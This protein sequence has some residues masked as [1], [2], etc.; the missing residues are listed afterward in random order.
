MTPIRKILLLIIS[1]LLFVLN[2]RW[3]FLHDKD[4]NYRLLFAWYYLD[5]FP[6]LFAYAL[7]LMINLFA[8]TLLV[9]S[10]LAP[11]TQEETS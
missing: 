2:Q 4:N 1:M 7:S 10:L 6:E 9:R 3:G 11:I 8:A 5:R